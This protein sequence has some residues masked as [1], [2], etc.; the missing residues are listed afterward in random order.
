MVLRVVDV[1]V[2]ALHFSLITPS[3][4][5]KVLYF[6]SLTASLYLSP[7]GASPV[8]GQGCMQGP[9]ACRSSSGFEGQSPCGVWDSG[10]GPPAISFPSFYQ[11]VTIVPV[12]AVINAEF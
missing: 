2:R 9:G 12:T 3:C 7:T 5:D 6:L 1:C 4:G 8:R 10:H 11:G